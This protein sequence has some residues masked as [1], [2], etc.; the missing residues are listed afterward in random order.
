GPGWRS[1]RSSRVSTA[2]GSRYGT[3]SATGWSSSVDK[4]GDSHADHDPFLIA[5]VLNRDV[6][7]A[8]RDAAEMLIATC[9]DCAALHADL[10]SLSSAVA[11]LP[12]P[13]RERDFRL[14]TEDAARLAVSSGEPVATTP[15]LAGVMTV[16][17]VPASHAAHDPLL[18]ASLADHSLGGAERGAAETLVGGCPACADLR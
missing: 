15:R 7:P 1:E 16:R 4:Q 8:E 18:V 9:P 10:L 6:E 2:V 17:R 11:D 3:C 14:T 5:A 12:A 13:A